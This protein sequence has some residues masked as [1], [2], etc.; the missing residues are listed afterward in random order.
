MYHGAAFL[1]LEMVGRS[2]CH[3]VAAVQVHL[4]HG[5][6]FIDAHLVKEAVAQNAGVVDDAVHPAK[7]VDRALHDAG[8]GVGVGHAVGVGHGL[9]T[10]SLDLVDHFLRGA[11]VMAFATGRGADVVDHDLRAFLGH[12]QRHIAANAAAGAGDD[13]NFAFEHLGHVCFLGSVFM[14]CLRGCS[15]KTSL[16]IRKSRG[17]P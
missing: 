1:F 11:V 3:V 12:G 17:S 5:V 14:E 8:C 9:A 10:S 13:D 4:D 6:P 15:P 7:G 2:A 16:P